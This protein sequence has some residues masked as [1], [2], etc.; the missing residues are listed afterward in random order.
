M[1]NW[2]EVNV[3]R[4]SRVEMENWE[5]AKLNYGSQRDVITDARFGSWIY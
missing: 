4:I 5:D 2:L 3:V 1:V